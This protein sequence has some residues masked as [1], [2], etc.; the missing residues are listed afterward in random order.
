MAEW[1]TVSS[2]MTMAEETPLEDNFEQWWQGLWVPLQTKCLNVA[3]HQYVL[4]RALHRYTL[5]EA[6]TWEESFDSLREKQYLQW[7]CQEVGLDEE[8]FL[9]L[10][11]NHHL[12]AC[13][14][15]FSSRVR[16]E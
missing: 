12:N 4:Q 7:L 10:G 16:Q 13:R 6:T 9:L 8:E 5:V 1:D 14:K 15:V 3:R 2:F 11:F